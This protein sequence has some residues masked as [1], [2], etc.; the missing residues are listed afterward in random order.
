MMYLFS[1]KRAVHLD[2]FYLLYLHICTLYVN[3]SILYLI[4]GII[5]TMDVTIHF[6]H[7]T[8]HNI[9]MISKFK[10]DNVSYFYYFYKVLF[11]NIYYV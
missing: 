5:N 7:D 6:N 8:I 11:I 4:N 3:E 1:Y 2:L 9:F 10:A